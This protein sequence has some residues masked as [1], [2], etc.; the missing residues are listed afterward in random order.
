MQRQA[1]K[2]VDFTGKDFFIRLDVHRKSCSITIV[3]EG[4]EHKA[5]T[6]PQT[7]KL[8]RNTFIGLFPEVI[9][10]ALMKPDIVDLVFTTDLMILG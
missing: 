4:M 2:K 3:G 1:T 6:H 9:T 10:T 8:C 7:A 5:F